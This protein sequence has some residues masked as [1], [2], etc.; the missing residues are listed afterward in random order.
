MSNIDLRT[1][2][3]LSSV[4]SGNGFQGCHSGVVINKMSNPDTVKAA[5]LH[6][7]FHDHAHSTVV[8]MVCGRDF[9]SGRWKTPRSR[10]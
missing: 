5:I 4:S 2:S 1:N 8:D 10:G 9:Q 6:R 3:V 7:I